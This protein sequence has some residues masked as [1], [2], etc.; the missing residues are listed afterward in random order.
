MSLLDA[1]KEV[2]QSFNPEGISSFSFTAPI[3]GKY[4]LAAESK[5]YAGSYHVKVIKTND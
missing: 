4:E 2:I 1:N 5:Q 3:S